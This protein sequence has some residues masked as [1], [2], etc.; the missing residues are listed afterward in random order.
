MES[1]AIEQTRDTPRRA[2]GKGE[3]GWEGV[4][5]REEWKGGKVVGESH[6]VSQ[7]SS[8]RSKSADMK[9]KRL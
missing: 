7:D 5:G 3:G 8:E 4:N 1:T 9:R 6:G 2:E